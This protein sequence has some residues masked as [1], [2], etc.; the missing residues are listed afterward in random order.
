MLRRPDPSEY[1]KPLTREQIQDYKNQGGFND[2][3]RL[4]YH[5]VTQAGAA[6]AFEEVQR[7]FQSIFLGTNGSDGLI[8]DE[9]QLDGLD[10]VMLMLPR[11]ARQYR[12]FASTRHGPASERA[13]VSRAAPTLRS[14]L[15]R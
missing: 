6:V 11:W 12:R 15:D 8:D 14:W 4:S 3:W 2:D 9:L 1:D 7:Y 13:A 5:A 10:S